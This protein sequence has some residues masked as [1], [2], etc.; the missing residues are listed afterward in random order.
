MLERVRDLAITYSVLSD[1]E[2]K[3]RTFERFR[4]LVEGEYRDE[5][6][7]VAE[8]L[9]RHGVWLDKARSIER[10]EWFNSKIRDCKRV[11]KEVVDGD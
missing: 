2:C 6:V 1:E 3:Q 8:H 9:R 4:R 5:A 10:I 7:M 11:W